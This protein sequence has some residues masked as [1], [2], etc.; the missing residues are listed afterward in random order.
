MNDADELATLRAEEQRRLEILQ[1]DEDA[2][3]LEELRLSSQLAKELGV[4]GKD[5]EIVNTT[6]GVFGVRKPDAQGIAQW[7]KAVSATPPSAERLIGILRHYVVPESKKLEFHAVASER[8][9]IAM[10]SYSVAAA[11]QSLTGAGRFDAK[12]K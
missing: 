8:P 7:D 11:F 6:F 2:R 10:G 5:F 9:G 4:R 1:E 3:E 12:K